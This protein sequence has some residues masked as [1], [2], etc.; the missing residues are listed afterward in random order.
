MIQQKCI[1]IW[2]RKAYLLEHNIHK[3]QQKKFVQIYNNKIE[4]GKCPK[5]ISFI[6][7]EGDQRKEK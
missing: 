5:K 2:A 4:N 3:T 1:F 7:S 6:K